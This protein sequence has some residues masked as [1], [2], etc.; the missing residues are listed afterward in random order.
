MNLIKSYF[1]QYFVG[2]KQK[3]KEFIEEEIKKDEDIEM[4]DVEQDNNEEEEVQKQHDTTIEQFKFICKQRNQLICIVTK[5]LKFLDVASFLAPGYSYSK[6]W[7][8][9]KA[10][11]HMNTLH[12]WTS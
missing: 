7:K 2:N 10:F 1:F 11:S 12:P 8:N 9:R 5:K 3:D 4:R 6:K